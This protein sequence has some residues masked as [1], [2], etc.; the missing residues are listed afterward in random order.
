MA[1]VNL[2]HEF[3]DGAEDGTVAGRLA[4]VV[5][6]LTQFPG[7]T[8]VSFEID[9]APTAVFGPGGFLI[10]PPA[11]RLDFP[12]VLP[13]VF[14]DQPARGSTIE[15]PVRLTGLANVFEAVLHVRILDADGRSLA[16]GP[17]TATCGSGCWGT[18]DVTVP[19]VVAAPAPGTIQ[20]YVL[21]AKDGSIE[22]L[23]EVPVTLTP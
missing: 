11:E 4:Q 5:F 12:D 15:N 7:V 23:V 19:Y 1:V 6:T 18:F 8:G 14:L 16:D 9:G 10:N 2:S 20:A 3:E 13:P 22:D 21:S 17:V